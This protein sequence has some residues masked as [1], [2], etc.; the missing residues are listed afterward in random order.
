[1]RKLAK[2]KKPEAPSGGGEWLNTYADMVTLLLAF[3]AV[4][5][6]MSNT[7]PVKFNA[8]IQSFSNLP[9]DVQD[10]ILGN[11]ETADG[12]EVAITTE[13]DF[14]YEQIK[15]HVDESNTQASVEVVKLDDVIYIRFE[16]AYFF[17]PSDYVLLDSSVPLLSSIGSALIEFEEFI[18][19]VNVMGFTATIP[20]PEAEYIM[21]AAQRA[22]VVSSHFS[23]EMGFTEEKISTHG[24]GNRFPVAPN[25]SEENMRQNRRVEMVIISEAASDDR[26]LEDIMEEFYGEDSFE[27]GG[28]AGSSVLPGNAEDFADAEELPQDDTAVLDDDTSS[29]IQEALDNLEADESQSE[30]D[31]ENSLEDSDSDNDS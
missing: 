30:S 9:Q 15:Q 20:N 10:E 24:Y 18:R 1:M 6:S 23:Y 19:M 22:A 8:F 3:F 26:S 25:D 5:L 28:G 11:S 21:L 7:D 13:F 27:T 17:E 29:L 31:T 16:S 12:E 14:L 4:L 2:R